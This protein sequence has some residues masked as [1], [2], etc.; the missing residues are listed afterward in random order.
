MMNYRM[1]TLMMAGALCVAAWTLSAPV[2]AADVTVGADALSSYVWRGITVNKDAVVQPSFAVE[3]DSGLALEVWAN[4]DIGDNDGDFEKGEFSEIDFDVS[5]TL[6]LNPVSVT[7][8]YVEYT[9]P[10]QIER[11]GNGDNGERDVVYEPVKA[12]RDVYVRVAMELPYG[13]EVDLSVYQDL[14]TSEGTYALL[15]GVYAWPLTQKLTLDVSGS[16]GY[17]AKEATAGE[18]AGWHDYQVGL[19][20][21]FGWTEDLLVQAFVH[22]VGSLDSEV[23]PSESIVRDIYGGMGIYYSF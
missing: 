7:L 8:G 17:G 3:H 18:K 12:D 9:Y 11:I 10:A 20:V 1:N 14:S 19:N 23:L 15:T 16:V 5:Y 21:G 22:H 13:F 2:Q 6:D 4:F